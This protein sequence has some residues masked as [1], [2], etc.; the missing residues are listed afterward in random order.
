MDDLVVED[1]A[2]PFRDEAGGLDAWGGIDAAPLPLDSGELLSSPSAVAAVEK[3]VVDDWPQ[4]EHRLCGLKGMAERAG[5]DPMERA[6]TSVGANPATSAWPTSSGG[7]SSRPHN[8]CAAL[9]AVRV[10]RTSKTGAAAAGR[11]PDGVHVVPTSVT[12]R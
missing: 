2:R 6:S 4:T 7:G 9:S 8:C 5:D 11:T 12:S 10:R 3:T 1:R